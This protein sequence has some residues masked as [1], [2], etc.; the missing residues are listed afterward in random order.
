MADR[1]KLNYCVN[2]LRREYPSTRLDDLKALARDVFAS[3]TEEVALTT[4]S[5]EGGAAGGQIKFDKTLLGLAIEK[6]LAEYGG[7]ASSRVVFSSF[8]NSFIET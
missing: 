5:F 6:L 2:Y 1:D 4:T 3:A 7:A 8:N